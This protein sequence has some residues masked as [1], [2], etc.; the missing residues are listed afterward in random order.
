[1]EISS[2]YKTIG[3]FQVKNWLIPPEYIRL[4]ILYLLN[5]NTASLIFEFEVPSIFLSVSV[6]YLFLKLFLEIFT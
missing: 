1:M 4:Q 5:I 6:K 2:L 3:Y